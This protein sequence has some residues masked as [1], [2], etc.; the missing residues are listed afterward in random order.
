MIGCDACHGRAYALVAP[1]GGEAGQTAWP[2]R[3]RGLAGPGSPP[4]PSPTR[5]TTSTSSED[6]AERYGYAL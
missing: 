6:D 3:V 2:I 5:S 4:R 1:G